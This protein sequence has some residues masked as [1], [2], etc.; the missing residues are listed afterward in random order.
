MRNTTYFLFKSYIIFYNLG[1]PTIAE[2]TVKGGKK[3]EAVVQCALEACRILDRYNLL[4]QSNHE[5]RAKRQVKKWKE[6]DYYDSDEDEFLDRTG[7]IAIKRQKR[8]QMENE[9]TNKPVVDTFESLQ[10][11]YAKLELLVKS[12]EIQLKKAIEAVQEEKKLQETNNDDLDAF[13]DQLQKTQK[14]GGREQV[15]KLRQ[16]LQSQQ[17]EL[18]R[19]EQLVNLAKPTELPKLQLNKSTSKSVMIGKRFGFGKSKNLRTIETK[20]QTISKENKVSAGA[21]KLS[22]EILNDKLIDEVESDKKVK[23]IDPGKVNQAKEKPETTN[24]V[25]N[26]KTSL[27]QNEQENKTEKRVTETQISPELQ[28][29]EI[30]EKEKIVEKKNRKRRPNKDTSIADNVRVPGDYESS[31]NDDKYAT[32]VPPANQSGDGRT[33]LNDKYGY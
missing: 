4:R 6:D 15:S 20:P 28:M 21:Q 31:L 2:A 10:E 26:K 29:T 25:E 8:M 22:E 5:S 14:Y 23:Q 24:K 30:E 1:C 32:W 17:T 16:L 19:L 3:K 13:M 18:K 33:S 7:T 11:K 27:F 12:T 9:E